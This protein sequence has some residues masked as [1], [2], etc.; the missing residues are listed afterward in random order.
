MPERHENAP[1]IVSRVQGYESIPGRLECL[2]NDFKAVKGD[3]NRMKK[4][5]C[6]QCRAFVEYETRDGMQ[7]IQFDGIS[8]RY[9]RKTAMCTQCG[10][11]LNVPDVIT[12]NVEA[13]IQA[14]Y[15]G[16]KRDIH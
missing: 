8:A 15:E 11:V 9:N 1:R 13:R 4:S 10:N 5:W 2:R 7:D 16:T 12:Q 3:V 6:P 14:I